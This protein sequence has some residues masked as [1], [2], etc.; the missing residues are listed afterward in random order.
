M[1]RKSIAAALRCVAGP[2][3]GGR[4]ARGHMPGEDNSNGWRFK[5]RNSHTGQ[6]PSPGK[7]GLPRPG[8]QRRRL[9]IP[10]GT[11]YDCAA[12]LESGLED[13]AR[14]AAEVCREERRPPHYHKSEEVAG[15]Y[16]ASLA[17]EG[18]LPYQTIPFKI[19]R[20]LRLLV[21]VFT[22]FLTVRAAQ[23]L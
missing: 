7:L 12:G 10:Q 13:V 16:T 19:H 8:S 6:D 9:A 4:C 14:V 20:G 23:V 11:G 18:P 15:R 17:E 1:S 2:A 22:D 5:H 3:L 21:D